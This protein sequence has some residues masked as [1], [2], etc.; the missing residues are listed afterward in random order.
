MKLIDI[1]VRD[2]HKF[3]GWPDGAVECHRFVDEANIDFYDE[4][5]NWDGDCYL[6]YGAEFAR[7]A[8]IKRDPDSGIR[9]ESVTREQYEA[10][11][12]ASKIAW[13]GEG[14]PPPGVEFEYLRGN[15]GADKGRWVKCTM[16][17]AGEK[18]CIVH[19]DDEGESWLKH[20]G[21]QIRPILS[22]ADRKKEAALSQIANAI[23]G[24]VP[25]TGMATAAMYA[26]R[27]YDAIK[28]GKIVIE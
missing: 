3:G 20:E 1:L 21:T 19:L 24:D 15:F 13:D 14:L 25:D 16:K 27:I 7:E 28:S 6:K 17:Y 8:V 22:E 10:A 26:K 4:K 9:S 18:Y 11:L 5:D 23:I 2:L 12:S